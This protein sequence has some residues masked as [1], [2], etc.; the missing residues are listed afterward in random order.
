MF[1]DRCLQPEPQDA[2]H[3]PAG[4]K[5]NGSV[6]LVKWPHGPA[7]P[8]GPHEPVPVSHCGAAGS[9]QSRLPVQPPH[10]PDKHTP[11]G[12]AVPSARL[13]FVHARAPE[14]PSAV[15]GFPS[16]QFAQAPPPMPQAAVA[17]PTTQIAPLV[18]VV[19]VWVQA[20]PEQASIV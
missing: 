17:V 12:Q 2:I 16:L 20:P 14:Q 5:Q 13:T 1:S 19:Q 18:H 6:G 7:P 4:S 3:S 11:V 9:R 10:T 8:Q 15:H